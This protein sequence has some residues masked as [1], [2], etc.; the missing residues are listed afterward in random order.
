MLMTSGKIQIDNLQVEDQANVF[1]AL[2]GSTVGMDDIKISD[3]TV[4]EYNQGIFNF[5]GGVVSINK[6]TITNIIA[7]LPGY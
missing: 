3:V 6:F 7:S 2:L 5:E 1:Y 4:G